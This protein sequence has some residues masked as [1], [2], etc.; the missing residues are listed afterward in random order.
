MG[1][2]KLKLNHQTTFKLNKKRKWVTPSRVAFGQ[3]QAREYEQWREV[4]AIAIR[5]VHNN[6]FEVQI[7][8]HIQSTLKYLDFL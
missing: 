1:K 2:V 5:G 3:K 4:I 7:H 8:N 6:Q